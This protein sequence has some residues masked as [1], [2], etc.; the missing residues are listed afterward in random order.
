MRGA[1]CH[2]CRINTLASSVLMSNLHPLLLLLC[3]IRMKQSLDTHRWSIEPVLSLLST[4]LV[5]S[6]LLQCLLLLHLWPPVGVGALWPV[7]MLG[8]QADRRRGGWAGRGGGVGGAG[9]GGASGA[10]VRG[11]QP[12][13][14]RA[15]VGADV[16][17][18]R[19]GGVVLS[20][21][22]SG[23][24]RGPWQM[25]RLEPADG[26]VAGGCEG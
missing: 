7:R 15:M 25:Q 9:E 26:W 24:S 4:N 22:G 2:K 20:D 10:P 1:R 11:P 21:R 23:G 13:L 18:W 17:A 19:R 3:P 8:L 16:W 5:L 6:P 12:Q 14:A